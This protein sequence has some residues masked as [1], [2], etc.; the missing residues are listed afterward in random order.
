[1]DSDPCVSLFVDA[2]GATQQDGAGWRLPTNVRPSPPVDGPGW[3]V[4]LS[5]PAASLARDNTFHSDI[6]VMNYVL[7]F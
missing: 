3:P 6:L 4:S 7:P 1:M 2:M 5:Q